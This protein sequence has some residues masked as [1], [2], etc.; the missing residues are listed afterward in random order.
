[1][2]AVPGFFLADATRLAILDAFTVASDGLWREGEQAS[3]A[4][5][6][7]PRTRHVDV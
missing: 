2:L 1:M 6:N 5:T 7:T 4:K 3:P